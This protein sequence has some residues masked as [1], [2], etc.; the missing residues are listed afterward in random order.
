MQKIP[1]NIWTFNVQRSPPFPSLY[2]FAYNAYKAQGKEES[3]RK[4]ESVIIQLD[5]VSAATK[6][7]LKPCQSLSINSCR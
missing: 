5:R 4:R 2:T 1:F 6:T 7:T 3:H